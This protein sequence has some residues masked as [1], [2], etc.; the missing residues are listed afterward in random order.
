MRQLSLCLLAAITFAACN[1]PEAKEKTPEPSAT[2][3]VAKRSSPKPI[4]PTPAKGNWMWKDEKGKARDSDPLGVKDNS[5]E[6][7]KTKK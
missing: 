6:R 7:P 2:P 5:L 3:T 1:K 4:S